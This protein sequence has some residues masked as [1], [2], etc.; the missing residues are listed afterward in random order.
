MIVLFFAVSTCNIEKQSVSHEVFLS[1]D[2][3]PLLFL[4]LW[5]LRCP[6]GMQA[7]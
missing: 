2:I 3:E 1:D 7:L 5:M 4:L 6:F